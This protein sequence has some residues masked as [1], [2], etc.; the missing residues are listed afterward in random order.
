VEVRDGQTFAISGLLSDSHRNVI[1]KFPVL[2][3][4]PILGTLFRSSSYQKNETELVVLATPHLVKPMTVT[5][6][7]LPT[8]R[9]VEP[10]DFE[11]YLLGAQQG[12]RKKERPPAPVPEAFPPGFGHQPVD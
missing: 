4:I 3:D 5:Q 11:F 8:D 10:N 12:Q 7:R 6:A 9:Y 2:G 1:N